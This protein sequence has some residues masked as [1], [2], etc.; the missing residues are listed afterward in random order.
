MNMKLNRFLLLVIVVLSAILVS[1]CT[2]SVY[3]NSLPHLKTIE[4]SEFENKSEEYGLEEDLSDQLLAKFETDRKLK[5]VS[6]NPDC[7]LSGEILDYSD[8]IKGYSESDEIEEYE[9]KIL[10]NVQF[11]DLV[12]NE[13]LWSNE[14]LLLSE[15]Y[16]PNETESNTIASTPE[17]ALQNIVEDLYREILKNTLEEW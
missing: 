6:L 17:E 15:I 14:S 9:I 8:K 5:I 13:E 4:I 2:Y 7:T 1:S 11:T 3:S 10:L 16:A 12:K